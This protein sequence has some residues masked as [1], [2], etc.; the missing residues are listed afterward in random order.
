MRVNVEADIAFTLALTEPFVLMDI[1]LPGTDG[2]TATRTLRSNDQ[3][4]NIPALALITHAMRG[5]ES[6]IIDAGCDGY[7]ANPIGDNNFLSE[8]DR[9]LARCTRSSGR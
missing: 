3:T 6:R 9:L 7:V 2:L 5:D 1:Q 4:A 8:V